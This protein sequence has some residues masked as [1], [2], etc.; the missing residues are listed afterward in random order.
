VDLL[1][2]AVVALVLW[3]AIVLLALALA[4]AAGRA[5]TRE[6]PQHPLD[7]LAKEIE[8]ASRLHPS[9]ENFPEPR[10]PTRS[11]IRSRSNTKAQRP[12]APAHV[13]K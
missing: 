7:A 13:K 3:V 12:P 4:R 8:R 10:V 2:I 11:A 1:S 9:P 6:E 5:D